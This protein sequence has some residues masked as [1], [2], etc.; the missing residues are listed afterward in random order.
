MLS[1]DPNTDSEANLEE[2]L[3]KLEQRLMNPVFLKNQGTK[4]PRY[5]LQRDALRVNE[6]YGILRQR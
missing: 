2:L 6:C 3:L 5:S 4:I 1:N